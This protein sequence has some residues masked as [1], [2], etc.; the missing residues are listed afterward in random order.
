VAWAQLCGTSSLRMSAKARRT[1]SGAGGAA[2]RLAMVS[3]VIAQD[4]RRNRPGAIVPI[5]G[6]PIGSAALRQ[7]K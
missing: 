3:A 4:Q 5:A 6:Y 2:E 1:S 7:V